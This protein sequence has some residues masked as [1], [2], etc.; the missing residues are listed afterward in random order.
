[1]EVDSRTGCLTTTAEVCDKKIAGHEVKYSYGTTTPYITHS[2]TR[3]RDFS[4]CMHQDVNNGIFKQV[5]PCELSQERIINGN[6]KILFS[7]PKEIVL[8]L[9]LLD[10]RI[11]YR[12]LMTS[13]TGKRILKILAKYMEIKR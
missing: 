7:K 13:E 5:F 1:M 3:T 9:M 11:A 6:I 10:I 2:P 12:F 8:Y 4:R